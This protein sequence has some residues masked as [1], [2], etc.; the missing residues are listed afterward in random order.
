MTSRAL[1]FCGAVYNFHL[2][3]AQ[4]CGDV[5][6]WSYS[7]ELRSISKLVPLKVVNEY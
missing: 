6:Y 1:S 3:A 7:Q 2:V 5:L 4:C